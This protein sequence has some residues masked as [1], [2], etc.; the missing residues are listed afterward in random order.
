MI[1]SNLETNKSEK[2]MAGLASYHYLKTAPPSLFTY[3][4]GS[5]PT[6]L[7]KKFLTSNFPNETDENFRLA[8]TPIN[9]PATNLAST[10][11]NTT[12]VSQTPNPASNLTNTAF[13]SPTNNPSIATPTP[14]DT[15]PPKNKETPTPNDT[16]PP[17][18]KETPTPENNPA[19]PENHPATP[20]ASITPNQRPEDYDNSPNTEKSTPENENVLNITCD[21]RKVINET[22]HMINHIMP[23]I[24]Y[25]LQEIY[26][27]N[28]LEKKAENISAAK[29]KYKEIYSITEETANAIAEE[30]P[31]N[32]NNMSKLIAAQ[33]QEQVRAQ[34]ANILKQE[35]RKNSSGGPETHVMNA[36][37]SNG[38]DS[39]SSSKASRISKEFHST[40][41]TD[42][43]MRKTNNYPSTPPPPR[44]HHSHIKQ[45]NYP[46]T[47]LPPRLH[48]SHIKHVNETYSHPPHHHQKRQDLHTYNN[49][50]IRHLHSDNEPPYSLQSPQ[51]LQNRKKRTRW[52]PPPQHW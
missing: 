27:K 37:L 6:F 10:I 40:N 9:S 7:T 22:L 32:H 39:R 24:T 34:L 18:D 3:M 41:P 30:T 8:R 35:K 47:P 31:L 42:P 20:D 13:I 51:N 29:S 52:I 38:Q 44:P 2:K 15:T 50:N 26:D 25:E 33:V 43:S 19:T 11:T 36:Q 12:L 48:H 1:T 4:N 45:T 23:K 14:N 17:K 28:L 49:T 16:T 21:E 5:S 46:S